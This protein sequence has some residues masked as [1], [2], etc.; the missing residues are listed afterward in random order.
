MCTVYGHHKNENAH[1]HN[2]QTSHDRQK[3]HETCPT[4]N[5]ID[6]YGHHKN[7]DTQHSIRHTMTVNSN[8]FFLFLPFLTI[9]I[10]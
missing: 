1:H 5:L 4:N 3:G 9:I 8:I 2:T 7:D 10:W 6:V